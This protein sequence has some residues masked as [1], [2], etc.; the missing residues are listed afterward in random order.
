MLAA[1]LPRKINCPDQ[2]A[3]NGLNVVAEH[4]GTLYLELQFFLNQDQKKTVE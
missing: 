3:S 1:T 4:P 2:P